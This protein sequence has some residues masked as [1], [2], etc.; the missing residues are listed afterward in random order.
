MKKC[1]K[2]VFQ[3]PLKKGFLHDVVQHHA[4]SF[5]LEGI[6]QAQTPDTV[7]II[8]FGPLEDIDSLVDVLHKE[9]AKYSI[10]H[11]EIESFL[12]DRDYRGIFRVIE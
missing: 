2:I 10:T 3:V 1:V 6:A 9:S 4:R 7:K 11:I 12:K 8:A 5:G